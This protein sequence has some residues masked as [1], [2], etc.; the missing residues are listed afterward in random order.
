MCQIACHALLQLLPPALDFRLREVL[1]AVIHCFELA[2]IDRDAGLREQSHLAA[3][4][5]EARADFFDRRPIVLA[6]IGNR[7]EVRRQPAQE[8]HNLDVAA[9][10]ALE[11]P[12]RPVY[13]QVPTNLLSAEAQDP[14]P[15]P[16]PRP[17]P[18]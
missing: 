18:R 8:P 3:H 17:P 16:D 9:R 6:E 11:P 12:R 7:L 14:A 10:L 13:L 2:A 15:A 5:D 4:L 1:V